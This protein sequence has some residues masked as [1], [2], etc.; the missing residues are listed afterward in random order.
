MSTLLT[1]IKIAR[2]VELVELGNKYQIPLN[3]RN[4]KTEL[5][6]TLIEELIER[7]ILPPEARKEIC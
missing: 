7:D 5:Y 3:I 6:N 2:K 4:R 1:V